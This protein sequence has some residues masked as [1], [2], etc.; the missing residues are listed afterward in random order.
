M[1]LDIQID[2]FASNRYVIISEVNPCTGDV[3]I[4]GDSDNLDDPQYYYLKANTAPSYSAGSTSVTFVRGTEGTTPNW[5]NDE[6]IGRILLTLSGPYIGKC[7]TITDNTSNVIYVLGDQQNNDS[8]LVQNAYYTVVH[9]STTM[10]DYCVANNFSCISILTNSFKFSN[11][12]TESPK[13]YANHTTIKIGTGKFK[14][15]ILLSDC[16][17]WAK[18]P[19][20]RVWK[21]DQINELVFNWHKLNNNKAV[22]LIITMSYEIDGSTYYQNKNAFFKFADDND[23]NGRGYMKGFPMKSDGG[24]DMGVS[25]SLSFSEAWNQQ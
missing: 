11:G 15:D 4:D 20:D 10:Y 8:P 23:I 21:M 18:N 19:L 1:S 22:Y 12:S 25:F 24:V 5:T 14:Q 7:Y 13:S 2:D 9:T 3:P 16:D 6:L 17:V